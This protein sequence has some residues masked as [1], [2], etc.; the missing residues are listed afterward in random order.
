M[1]RYVGTNAEE[2]QAEAI[3]A[4]AHAQGALNAL[5]SAATARS[6]AQPAPS[7]TELLAQRR[8][9]LSARRRTSK[10]APDQAWLL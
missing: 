8:A 9:E 10:I 1:R 4:G 5:L 7:L 6:T 3:S 2:I